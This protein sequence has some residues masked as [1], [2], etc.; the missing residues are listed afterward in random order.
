M[1]V[2]PTYRGYYSLELIKRWK[3]FKGLHPT[4]QERIA[5]LMVASRGK[6][7]IGEGLRPATLQLQLFLSRH[8]PDPNGRIW[9]DGKTWSRL[10]GQAA[11]VP[12]GRS[13]HELGL[14]ADLT[15][16]MDWLGD[17]AAR[18]ELRTFADVNNEPWHVQ[19]VEIAKGRS[20]YT[21]NP[22]WGMPPWD[23]SSGSSG[24]SGSSSSSGS[25]GSSG[26][27]SRT[28]SGTD[29]PKLLQLR[30]SFTVAPGD[31]GSGVAVMEEV[32]IA[33][34]LLP[35]EPA[36]RDRD[37]GDDDAQIVR[38]FQ[39]ANQLFVD[40]I[41]GPQTWGSLLRVIKPDDR[42]DDVR[43]LQ[44]ALIERRLMRDTSGNRDG[45]YGTGTQEVIGQF[46]EAAGLLVDKIVGAATWT[47]LI[48]DRKRVAVTRGDEA[49]ESEGS[50]E[51]YDDIDMLEVLEG[52]SA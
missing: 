42:S 40:G 49:D 31:S 25:S 34:E 43:A 47:A 11:A 38:D 22:S 51:D 3:T 29:R 1:A 21:K 12:P 36:S 17:N 15:G 20:A 19:P 26:S 45:V 24:S 48:G 27:S 10:P 6:V 30:P 16:D 39:T 5:D 50:V 14:A 41:V 2:Y 35:D 44:V 32:L 52:R 8:E 46:Q 33:R 23:S 28:G 13:M 4:M 37:Y 7:G 9:Y 18:F